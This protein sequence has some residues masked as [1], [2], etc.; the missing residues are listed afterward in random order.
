MYSRSSRRDNVAKPTTPV[1][2][3]D[4]A[5]RHSE[6]FGFI[7]PL[8]AGYVFFIALFSWSTMFS[9]ITALSECRPIL[10]GQPYESVNAPLQ[11]ISLTVSKP[12]RHRDIERYPDI[13]EWLSASRK[14]RC[15]SHG[16]YTGGWFLTRFMS[17][18]HVSSMTI[19]SRAQAGVSLLIRWTRFMVCSPSA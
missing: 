5:K 8:D 16:W 3:L 13:V 6:F 11:L 18:R 4:D 14:L 7:Y 9:L 12:G 19:R 1:V 10:R 15:F 17:V 2:Y